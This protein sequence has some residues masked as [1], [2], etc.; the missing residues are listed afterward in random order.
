MPC[1]GA[2][3]PRSAIAASPPTS[4]PARRASLHV[5]FMVAVPC[6]Y[7][8]RQT[9]SIPSDIY[10]AG[11]EHCLDAIPAPATLNL[12]KSDEPMFR[13]AERLDS[14]VLPFPSRPYGFAVPSLWSSVYVRFGSVGE[15]APGWIRVS[16]ILHTFP[17]KLVID[18]GEER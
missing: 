15:L 16:D 10:V 3:A 4:V 5:V 13:L 8:N 18:S 17:I 7:Q 2:T 12:E 11:V 14:T 6:L 1:A 9:I